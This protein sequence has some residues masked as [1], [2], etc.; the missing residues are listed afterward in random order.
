MPD[1]SNTI[2]SHADLAPHSTVHIGGAQITLQQLQQIYSE[3]TG[4][5]ESISKYY[6]DPIHLT[7]DDIELIHHRLIQTWEQYQLVSSTSSFTVYYLR[8]TKDQFNTFDRL[9]LQI[10][11]GSEPVESILLKYEFLILLRNLVKPQPYTVS[12]RVVSRLALEKRMREGIGS[13]FTLPRFIR[14]MGQS[15]ASVEITY[16]DYAV[17]RNFLSV[18]D[19]WL[20]TIPR[21][22]ENKTIKFLQSYSHWIPRIGRFVAVIV[23]T[24]I[25]L[26]ILPH[27]ITQ[28][29]N[30]FLRLAKFL[31][32]S[33]LGTYVAYTLAGWSA[34]FA[35]MAIDSWSEISYIK[36]NRGDEI[37][38][39]KNQRE[40]RHH[41]LRGVCGGLGTIGVD[42][43]A[44]L[45]A[46]AAVSSIGL[47]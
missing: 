45:A 11:G 41:L 6:D 10:G 33:A 39:A 9:K 16:V 3:L 2:H 40:N 15:T 7:L 30:S 36:L 21:S 19:D 35:E 28:E 25:V 27:F 42:I 26:S 13:P 18:I 46:M 47:P 17:A 20:R 44:K 5:S 24:L 43:V 14:L 31:L 12:I 1:S 38:I 32:W 4:K 29:E 22:Q 23:V 34:F 8:N 37:E